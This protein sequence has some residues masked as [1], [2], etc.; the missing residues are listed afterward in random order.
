MGAYYEGGRK[1][2][3]LTENGVPITKATV[4]IPEVSCTEDEVFIKDYAENKGV[5]M[6]ILGEG[7]IYPSTAKIPVG[8]AIAFRCRLTEKGMRLWE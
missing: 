4:N 3:L 7:F 1:A 2:I 5:Y 6:T 8:H